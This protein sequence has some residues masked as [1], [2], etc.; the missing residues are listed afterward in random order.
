MKKEKKSQLMKLWSLT[1]YD[2]ILYPIF[3][4]FAIR[5]APYWREIMGGSHKTKEYSKEGKTALTC[6]DNNNPVTPTGKCK[7]NHLK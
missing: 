7:T 3:A 5:V 1:G 6:D 4:A 2:F